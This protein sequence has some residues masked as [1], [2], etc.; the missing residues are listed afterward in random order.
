MINHHYFYLVVALLAVGTIFIRGFFIA[1]SG[2]MKISLPLSDLFTF[3]PAAIF[4]ALIIPATFFH[5][6]SVE[7]LQ[8]KERFF[9]LIVSSFACF[10]VRNTLFVISFGL[11]LLYLVTQSLVQET[12]SGMI[13]DQTTGLHYRIADGGTHKFKTAPLQIKT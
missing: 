12:I 7:L 11:I 4:P 2:K 6:G 10:F 13:I 1:L 9:I 8:G 3:I 5:Q